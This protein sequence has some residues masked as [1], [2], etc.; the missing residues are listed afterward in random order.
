MMAELQSE[1]E[2]SVSE[3]RWE[4][5]ITLVSR[6]WLEPIASDDLFELYTLVKVL[7]CLRERFGPPVSTGLIR[8]GRRQIAE[9][10]APRALIRVHF[11]QSPVTAFG[12]SS[13]YKA[14]L[15]GY[16]GFRAT[17]RRPDIILSSVAEGQPNRFLLVECKKSEDD[18][19]TRD[20]VYKALGYLRDF[21]GLWHDG[22]TSPKALV[23]FPN[24]ILKK[25][26]I[27]RTQRDLW[28]VGADDTDALDEAIRVL[29]RG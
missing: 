27:A 12:S 2:Y 13:E 4:S 21:A 24:T 10:S 14:T 3:S 23:V 29:A 5:I 11:D 18:G 7:E 17:S 22:A 25:L 8:A 20:S 9:F 26:G 15:E 16:E 19:Y 1:F 6:G 28:L